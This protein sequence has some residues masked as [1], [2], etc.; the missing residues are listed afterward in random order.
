MFEVVN[1]VIE[2]YGK[3][4]FDNFMKMFEKMFEVFDKYFEVVDCVN[5]VVIIMYG[6]FVCYFKYGDKKILVVIECLFLM[7]SILFEIVQ[8]VIVECFFFLVCILGDKLFKY[9]DQMFEVLMMF[10][11]YFEQCGVVY[12]LVGFVQG[13]GIV[14]LKEYCILVIFYSCFENKKDVCQCEFV[15]LVYELLLIILGCVFEFY[16]IQIVFQFFVGFGDVNVDVCEVV[17]VVV[18]VCFVKLSLYGVKQILFI[19]F[20]GFDD[21]QWCSKKGVCDLLGVM[22]YLDF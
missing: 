20:R 13:R 2:I 19:F 11:K 10:Q 21:D 3:G 17:L 4:I 16:V 5:E 7:F 12:G 18:K 14:V 1:I 8:Y 22:V 9:F 6:V 15:L